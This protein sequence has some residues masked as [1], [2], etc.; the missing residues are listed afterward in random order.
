MS[1][2]CENCGAHSTEVKTG[3]ALSAKGRKITLKVE[4]D[5]DLKRD[6]FKSDS[7][8]LCIPELELELE[9]GTL[10]GLFTTVEGILEKIS[11]HLKENNPF[12]CGDSIEGTYK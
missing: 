4:S 2:L 7:A 9:Y 8:Y 12:M 1:F 3:G 11:S 6:L 10:G 5:D